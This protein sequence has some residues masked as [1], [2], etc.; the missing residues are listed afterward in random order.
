MQDS[1]C[2]HCKGVGYILKDLTMY[3][4]IG[5]DGL[6]LDFSDIKDEAEREKAINERRKQLQNYPLQPTAFICPVCHGTGFTP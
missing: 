3:D 5:E 6:R 2:S 4:Y 1:K